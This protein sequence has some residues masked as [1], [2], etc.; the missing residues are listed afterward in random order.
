[1][2]KFEMEEIRSSMHSGCSNHP[3]L[4][5]LHSQYL[6]HPETTLTLLLLHCVGFHSPQ[7]MLLDEVLAAIP[8]IVTSYCTSGLIAFTGGAACTTPVRIQD[9]ASSTG[10]L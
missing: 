8:H 7:L 10:R 1:M 2:G 4:P 9:L 5:S 3:V 6:P